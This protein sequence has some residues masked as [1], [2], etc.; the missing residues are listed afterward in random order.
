M[1]P[2]LQNRKELTRDQLNRSVESNADATAAL[3]SENIL[4]PCVYIGLRCLRCGDLRQALA[5]LPVSITVLCPE[6]GMD[7][8]FVLLGKGLT[9]RSLPFHE[10]RW[11]ERE[12]T[13]RPHEIAERSYR[14]RL[15]PG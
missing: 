12:I 15:R 2:D 5:L 11:S 10:V 13:G 14:P 7:C 1:Q 6:C 9:R 8:S 4:A 3:G